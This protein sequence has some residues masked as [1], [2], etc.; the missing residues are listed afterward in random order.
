MLTQKKKEKK[1]ISKITPFTLKANYIFTYYTRTK[2]HLAR[3]LSKKRKNIRTKDGFNI[4]LEK[5]A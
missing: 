4:G 1:S 3:T 2:G 5:N